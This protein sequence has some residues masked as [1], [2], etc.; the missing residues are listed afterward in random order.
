[1]GQFKQKMELVND[2]KTVQKALVSV[3]LAM[4]DVEYIKYLEEKIK[5]GK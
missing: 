4:T 5:N 1:M 3:G 2:R